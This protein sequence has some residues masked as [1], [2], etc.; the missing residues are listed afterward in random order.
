MF[1]VL[2]HR[3]AADAV[4]IR[5]RLSPTDVYIIYA[6]VRVHILLNC[7]AFHLYD[8]IILHRT[9]DVL[10]YVIR[11]IVYNITYYVLY[12]DPHVVPMILYNDDVRLRET[13][14]GNS[15]TSRDLTS[16]ARNKHVYI[17]LFPYVIRQL[18]VTTRRSYFPPCRTRC[19]Q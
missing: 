8:T 6:P 7:I 15:C 4:P 1:G 9:Q 17:M 2:R 3:S 13:P 10:C 11:R 12:T 14:V 19:C 18:R 5:R 16:L